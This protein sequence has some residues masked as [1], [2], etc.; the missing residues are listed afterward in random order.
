RR[1]APDSPR[2][3][4]VSLHRNLVGAPAAVPDLRARRLLRLFADEAR[5]PARPRHRALVRARGELALVLR[6]RGVRMTLA[7]QDLV[8]TPDP[9]GAFPRLTREQLDAL[10]P[11]GERRPVRPGEVLYAQGER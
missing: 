1:G 7:A 4:G 3:S 11:A 2:L 6:A 9:H 10:C 8:E 5:T